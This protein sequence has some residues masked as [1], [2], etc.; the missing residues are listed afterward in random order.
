MNIRER[1]TKVLN[2]SFLQSDM[3]EADVSAR[4]G[5]TK[6]TLQ[7]W[8]SGKTFPTFPQVIEYF[9]AIRTRMIPWILKMPYYEDRK[10]NAGNAFHEEQ[11]HEFI[12]G[13]TP[14]QKER[15]YFILCGD[16]GSSVEG[17]L[18]MICAYLHTPLRERFMI[19][20]SVLLNYE[21]AAASGE[22]VCSG[23]AEPNV[24]IFEDSISKGKEAILHGLKKY[25]RGGK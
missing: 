17:L 15:L 16:H 10:P 21:V 25:V 18:E 24:E 23:T 22:E 12:K 19:S 9:L 5:I 8:L 7:S 11:I 6:K 2:D 20:S 1:C 14:T 13:L 3:S 4:L